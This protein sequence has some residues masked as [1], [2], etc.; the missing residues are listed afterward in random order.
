MIVTPMNASKQSSR[1]VENIVEL[2]ESDT[3]SIKS[4]KLSVNGEET[5]ETKLSTPKSYKEEIK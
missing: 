4:D 5:K 2:N 3:N 1:N